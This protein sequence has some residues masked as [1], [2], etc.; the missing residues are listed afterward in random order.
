MLFDADECRLVF[1]KRRLNKAHNHAEAGGGLEDI[2]LTG[3]VAGE[4]AALRVRRLVSGMDADAGETFHVQ[5]EGEPTA[6]TWATGY[7]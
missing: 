1:V 5:K 7:Q 3:V 4:N 6:E 2:A